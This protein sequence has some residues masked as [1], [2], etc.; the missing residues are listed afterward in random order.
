MGTASIS[1]ASDGL[2]GSLDWNGT[3]IVTVD[4]NG[5]ALPVQTVSASTTNT[6]TNK[7]EIVIGGVT[8]YI[9]ASTSGA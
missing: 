7:V 9:L 1:T 2:S 6:V 8:Y 5:V 4:G 3:P